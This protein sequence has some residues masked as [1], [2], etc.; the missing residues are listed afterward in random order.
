[1]ARGIPGT[2]RTYDAQN[3]DWSNHRFYENSVAEPTYLHLVQIQTLHF[4]SFV[5]ISSHILPL[6]MG[7]FV[8][9]NG[10]LKLYYIS[11]TKRKNSQMWGKLFLIKYVYCRRKIPISPGTYHETFTLTTVN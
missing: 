7:F 5:S 3:I 2:L 11:N 1:M 10:T 6:K 8:Y 9:T 4:C